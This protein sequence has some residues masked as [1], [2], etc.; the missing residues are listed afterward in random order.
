M[1]KIIS[2]MLC[3]VI[4]VA[5]MTGCSGSDE[6]FVQDSYTA[7]VAGITKV[8]I[9]VRDREIEVSLSADNQI[10]IDYYESS[11]EYYDISVSGDNVLTMTTASNKEWTDYI[12]G[13]TA[14]G[15][16]KISLQIPESLLTV[17]KL[18]TTNEDILL[19][20]LTILEDVELT[21]TGGDIIF[22]KLNV[23]NT[24]LISAK[25]GDISGAIVGSYDEYAVFCDIKKGES[26][27]PTEKNGGKKTL[28][29]SNNNGDIDI[30]FVNE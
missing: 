30:E 6:P 27:L 20:A 8:Y 29:V 18:S 21:S 13:K 4:G 7:E 28:T 1:K 26:N 3:L 10:H 25:N 12:G 5:V 19:P 22:D 11:K 16:R 24:I 14:T 2:L 17:L 15:Y 9:D 23:G